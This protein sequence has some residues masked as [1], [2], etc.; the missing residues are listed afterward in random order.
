VG[1]GIRCYCRVL[2]LP[3]WRPG[4][5]KRLK[6]AVYNLAQWCLSRN[7]D[8]QGYW[9]VGQLYRHV[10]EQGVNES[11]LDLCTVQ[12]EYD[13]LLYQALR[14]LHLQRFKMILARQKLILDGVNMLQVTYRFEALPAAELIQAGLH[15]TTAPVAATG[16]CCQVVLQTD[17]GRHY[18]ARQYDWVWPHDPQRELR[19]TQ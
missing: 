14:F 6:G 18:L 16:V 10:Q 13:P 11:C 4:G 9:A 7:N 15:T 5:R 19:R 8:F 2:T 3:E 1:P 12:V 17:Q